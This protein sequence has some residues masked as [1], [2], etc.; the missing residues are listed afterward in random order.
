MKRL[1]V[2]VIAMTVAFLV[3]GCV[4]PELER[5]ITQLQ[6]DLNDANREVQ[7]ANQEAEKANQKAEKLGKDLAFIDEHLPEL[8]KAEA[9]KRSCVAD[10]RFNVRHDGQ[11]NFQNAVKAG[12]NQR[13]AQLISQGPNRDLYQAKDITKNEFDVIVDMVKNLANAHGMKLPLDSLDEFPKC[14]TREAK[15]EHVPA[16]GGEK[17]SCRAELI[18]TIDL[19]VPSGTKY[20]LYDPDPSPG[21]IQNEGTEVVKKEQVGCQAQGKPIDVYAMLIRE[22]ASVDF[23]NQTFRV[24]SYRRIRLPSSGNLGQRITLKD[25]NNQPACP[26]ATDTP[27]A[28]PAQARAAFE[29]ILATVL[30]HQC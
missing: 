21:S 19:Q 5:Q 17:D 7:K 29:G 22:L 30:K 16:F 13:Q 20:W 27:G 9:L 6:E 10:A 12:M 28:I 25:V 2:G 23:P 11:G 4:D 3:I 14:P 15:S 26:A 1:S 8:V 24:V 18:R